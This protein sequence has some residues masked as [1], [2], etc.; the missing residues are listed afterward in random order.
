MLL[1][2][3]RHP[4]SKHTNYDRELGLAMLPSFFFFFLVLVM[5][6]AFGLAATADSFPF[7]CFAAVTPQ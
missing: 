6:L 4:L 5:V 3:W 7:R 2:G 1:R